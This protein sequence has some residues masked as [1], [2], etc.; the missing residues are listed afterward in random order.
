MT[1]SKSAGT[2][3]GWTKSLIT[4]GAPLRKS[5]ADPGAASSAT[6]T[7]PDLRV[8]ELNSSVLVI[9][10]LAVLDPES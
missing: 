6:T 5:N 1:W 10:S 4:P 2:E 7:T 3:E 9:L 8:W